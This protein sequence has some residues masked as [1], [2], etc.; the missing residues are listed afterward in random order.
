MLA[1]GG[2]PAG[3]C[4]VW[5]LSCALKEHGWGSGDTARPRPRSSRPAWDA[6]KLGD[7]LTWILD[8]TESLVSI[9]EAAVGL[10]CWFVLTWLF[11]DWQKH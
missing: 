7:K 6:G 1:P 10:S 5:H 3:V 8:L 2:S 9:N 11:P 4:R